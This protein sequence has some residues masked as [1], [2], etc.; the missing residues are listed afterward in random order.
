MNP[1]QNI[2]SIMRMVDASIGI[3][4]GKYMMQESIRGL[5]DVS[6]LKKEDAKMDTDVN[7]NI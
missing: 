2:A 4:A 1:R 6:S 7:I 3:H 5:S